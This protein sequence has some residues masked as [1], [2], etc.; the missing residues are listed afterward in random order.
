MNEYIEINLRR[1]NR[2]LRIKRQVPGGIVLDEPDP[3]ERSVYLTFDAANEITR[4]RLRRIRQIQGWHPGEFKLNV[5]VEDGSIVLRGINADSLPEGVYT[6]ALN[7][8]EAKARPAKKRVPVA[9]DGFGRLDV[10]V[11]LDERTVDADLSTCDAVIRGILER[12]IIDGQSAFEWLEDAS[13][14]PTRKA[15]L[16]NLLASLRARP[17]PR[18]HLA[19]NVRD[20]FW[21]GNDR[22]YA[23]VDREMFDR[24]EDL[25][26]DA[27][28]PFYREGR[29]RADIHLRLLEHLPEPP[30]RRVL[31]PPAG[32]VSFRG[33]GQPSLQAVIA[34]PPAG[35]DY[36]YAEFDLDLGNAL[37][38][39]SGLVVH[40][41][42][43][44]DGKSTNHLDLRSRL[45]KG[46]A[47]EFLYY[48]IA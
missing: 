48:G 40:M 33:E 3:I 15:C 30:E 29:P 38:D 35:S 31:F 21:M 10:I 32:L 43:L 27:T 23:T 37:Q 36:T 13:W 5:S 39:I 9:H 47:K 12:S 6:V 24:L 22:A 18:D 17:T 25:A 16:L 34:T 1:S 8:E 14:R 20:V 7:I 28:K 44:V 41:G 26:S 4:Y 11:E 42:E 2:P 19:R 45:A 46:T